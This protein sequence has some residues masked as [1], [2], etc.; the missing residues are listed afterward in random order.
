MREEYRQR[1][2]HKITLEIEDVLNKKIEKM[3]FLKVAIPLLLFVTHMSIILSNV[4]A[5]FNN[6][7]V[8]ILYLG[9][10][11]PFDSYKPPIS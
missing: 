6:R 4:Q 5:L 10:L 3:C 1:E 7:G 2:G 11:P 9:R 8:T